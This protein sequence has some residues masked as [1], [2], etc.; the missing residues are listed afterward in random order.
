MALMT[1]QVISSV[2]TPAFTTPTV[3][4]TIQSDEGLL[5]FVKIGVTATTVQ[6]VPFGN[7]EYSGVARSNLTTGSITSTERIFYIPKSIANPTTGL[8]TVTYSQVTNVTAALF[9]N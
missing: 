9:K 7:Q 1:P 3:S 5:L 6:I 4:D 8:V 2:I